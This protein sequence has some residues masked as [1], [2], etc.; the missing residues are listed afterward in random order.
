MADVVVRSHG[1]AHVEGHERH[2]PGVIRAGRRHARR[3]HVGIADRL[4]LFDVVL[5]GQEVEVREE[6]VEET[7]DLGRL[8]AVRQ[9]REVD[10]VGEQDRGRGELVRDRGVVGLEPLGDRPRQDVQ[11]EGLGTVLLDPQRRECLLA[12]ADERR[13]EPEHDRSRDGHVERDHRAREPRREWRPAATGQFAHDPGDEEHRDERDEPAHAGA[14][15]IEDE[16][17]ERREDAPQ[18]HGARRDEAA[19]ER[20]GDR[21]GEQDVEQLDPEQPLRVTGAGEDRDR[22][23]RDEQVQPGDEACRDAEGEVDRAPDER[24]RE[25]QDGD[26]D[27]QRLAQPKVFV[28]PRISSDSRGAIEPRLGEP[29]ERVHSPRA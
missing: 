20:H 16:G 26:E 23:D 11:Q 3:D 18:A 27:K 9:R 21:R 12:L 5:L 19:N 28:V 1:L 6:V 25:D 17:A 24:D 15:A 22:R 13:E 29:S 4:D 10:D 8:Q 7:D 2:H 14:R